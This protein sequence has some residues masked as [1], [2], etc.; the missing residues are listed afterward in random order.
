[1]SQRHQITAEIPHDLKDADELLVRY[2]RS[3]M[4]RYRKQHCASAEG[5]YAIPPNDDDRAPREMLLPAPDAA[6]VQRALFK[7]PERERLVLQ[8][9]YVPQRLP[10]EAQLRMKRIPV[11]LAAGRHL[12]GL[13]LFAERHRIESLLAGRAQAGLRR[14]ERRLA[15]LEAILAN[16]P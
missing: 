14:V 4:D 1:L 5:R 6:L 8:I 11:K 2:G 16:N 12:D 3:V 13:R 15:S 10:I 7:V 9:L